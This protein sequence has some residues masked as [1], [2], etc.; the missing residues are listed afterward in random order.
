LIESPL[1]DTIKELRKF[2]VPYLESQKV[3][4]S[5]AGKFKCINPDHDDSTP[6]TFIIP[7]S[8]GTAALCFGCNSHFTL[9]DAANIFEKLPIS[10]PGFINV[11]VKELCKRF[12]VPFPEGELTKEQIE[13]IEIQRAYIRAA[14]Y[15][16]Q[17]TVTAPNYV[18]PEL[19]SRGW[20][21][22]VGLKYGIGFIRDYRDFI[23]YLKRGGFDDALL[24]KAQLSDPK[25]FNFNNMIFT[26]F[27]QHGSP[28][29]FSGRN[30]K[31]NDESKES[32]YYNTSENCPLYRKRELLYGFH[33]A[34]KP[35]VEKGLIIV[36]GYPDWLTLQQ[37]SIDNVVALGGT[38]L[39][40][41]HVQI[42]LN[43]KITRVTLALDGDNGGR[44]ATKRILDKILANQ[45]LAIQ[46]KELPDGF[47]PDDLLK[48]KLPEEAVPIWQDVPTVSAF[49]WRIK[50]FKDVEPEEIAEKMIPIIVTEPSYVKREQLAKSLSNVTGIR[51][52]AILAELDSVMNKEKFQ[53]SERMN[54]IIKNM[55]KEL[56]RSPLQAK[57][58]LTRTASNIQAAEAIASVDMLSAV[59]V[60]DAFDKEVGEW[61]NRASNIIGIRTHFEEFDQ[62]INGL[63]ACKVA[64]FAGKPNHGKSCFLTNIAY[65]VAKLN[66]DCVVI[67]HST[68]DPR[69]AIFSRLVAIDQQLV[70]NDVTNP[71]YRMKLATPIDLGNGKFDSWDRERITKYKEGKKNIRSLIEKGKLILKD[72]TFGMTLG[73]TESLIKYY[74][75]RCDGRKILVIFDNFHKAE[76]FSDMGDERLRY[77]KM[78]ALSKIIAERQEISMAVSMQY[79]KIPEGIRP[80][81]FNIAESSQQSYDTS[82]ICHL[83]NDLKDNGSKAE[84]VNVIDAARNIKRPIVDIHVGKNKQA[85]FDGSLYFNFNPD[86]GYMTQANRQL[87][88]NLLQSKKS[89]KFKGM[90]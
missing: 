22:S 43:N 41:E 50:Q 35:A 26:I 38:A 88:T 5:P 34:R 46:V 76:D 56:K 18:E 14:D 84:L 39:T 89:D 87:I 33:I 62:A 30:L 42:I 32:K 75:E 9:F 8:E 17:S 65:N 47:D 85:S 63:Q 78:S 58:I 4:I 70:I 36:E 25:L 21:T 40:H 53:Q 3:D 80:T 24:F 71:N 61:Q 10:G 77:K 64:A 20:P 48:D 13:L 81:N 28:V 23:S 54:A 31:Y 69:G 68:D 67:Y 79:T 27:D 59:E 7:Q 73:H 74:K 6:S 19:E 72:S 55:E 12:D 52:Q 49:E 90:N 60:L 2:L 83:Y 45:P 57:E 15:I 37:D 29:G 1:T 86:Q 44:E 16:A 82:V 11:T 66:D 51:I